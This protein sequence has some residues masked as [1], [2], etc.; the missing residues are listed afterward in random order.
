MFR[1]AM[2]LVLQIPGTAYAARCSRDVAGSEGPSLE[3]VKP[4][5]G[6]GASHDDPK[7]GEI[8]RHLII[9]HR[10]DRVKPIIGD[11][12]AAPDCR[13]AGLPTGADRQ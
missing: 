11:G 12:R 10:V 13:P 3:K 9:S 7:T 2:N 5:C 8:K 6:G 1:S 4:R